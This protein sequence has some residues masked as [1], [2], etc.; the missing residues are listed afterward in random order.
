MMNQWI[1]QLLIHI[2]NDLT[3]GEYMVMWS[4][5]VVI[6]RDSHSGTSCEF[7][8]CSRF[9]KKK[10]FLRFKTF[11]EGAAIMRLILSTLTKPRTSLIHNACEGHAGEFLWSSAPHLSGWI[12]RAGRTRGGERF[13]GWNGAKYG[14]NCIGFDRTVRGSLEIVWKI[15]SQCLE[16]KARPFW[17]LRQA[18]GTVI[19]ETDER[20]KTSGGVQAKWEAAQSRPSSSPTVHQIIH[21]GRHTHAFIKD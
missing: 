9:K 7:S 13:I 18:Q 10:P 20:R 12:S 2:I 1:E 19:F 11:I 21:R 15:P 4:A 6:H 17:E 8:F 16:C 3:I 14:N 5:V